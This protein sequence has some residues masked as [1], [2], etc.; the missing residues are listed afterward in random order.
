MWSSLL[1]RLTECHDNR[2]QHR[3]RSRSSTLIYHLT[4]VHSV[5]RKPLRLGQYE[6]NPPPSEQGILEWGSASRSNFS[7]SLNNGSSYT[8]RVRCLCSYN[9]TSLNRIFSILTVFT[10]ILGAMEVGTWL[11]ALE[12]N[13]LLFC[14]KLRFRC[15]Q[16]GQCGAC[17]NIC[18]LSS[19]SSST[20]LA[21]SGW[22]RMSGSTQKRW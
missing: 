4:I 9:L 10:I 12:N 2:S 21:Q 19:R 17:V 15:I 16:Y 18:F 14:T 7:Q 6:H 5:R 20:W 1:V 11:R 13:G 8:L 3:T 22:R